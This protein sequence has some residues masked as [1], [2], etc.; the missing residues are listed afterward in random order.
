VVEGTM[1]LNEFFTIVG[2]L[3][4]FLMVMWLVKEIMT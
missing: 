4:L 3:W 1:R 2:V